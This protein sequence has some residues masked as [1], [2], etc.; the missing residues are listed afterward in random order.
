MC[1]TRIFRDK[2][3]SIEFRWKHYT[4]WARWSFQILNKHQVV[5]LRHL[6]YPLGLSSRIRWKWQL[7][8]LV[9]RAC[10][11]ENF[12]FLMNSRKRR[13]KPIPSKTKLVDHD[14]EYV[15]LI[16]HTEFIHL[17]N[18]AACLVFVSRSK[19]H[20]G[21]KMDFNRAQSAHISLILDKLKR[22]NIT[23]FC[24]IRVMMIIRMLR[25]FGR[26]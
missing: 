12:A 7:L 19:T 5:E 6:V 15:M 20:L 23:L 10:I 17:Q 26:W 16:P 18:S 11:S 21:L 8:N 14:T 24:I 9:S 4:I 2:K 13:K 22:A 1:K 25:E 3:T